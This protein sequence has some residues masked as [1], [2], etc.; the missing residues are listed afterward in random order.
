MI[1][2]NPAMPDESGLLEA[3]QGAI[4]VVCANLYLFTGHEIRCSF[5]AFTGIYF[6]V[7]RIDFHRKGNAQM[8]FRR[9]KYDL[10]RETY[11]YILKTGL[12]LFALT[13]TIGSF[14]ILRALAIPS[15]G[16]FILKVSLSIII[17]T[18]QRLLLSIAPFT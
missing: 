11:K 6:D 1:T 2:G 4:L 10:H 15:S 16:Q 5:G 8:H 12:I 9:P 18:L 14:K 3:L 7:Y 13:A 17:K